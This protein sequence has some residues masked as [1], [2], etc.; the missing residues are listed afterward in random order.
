M[1][2]YC[3]PAHTTSQIFEPPLGRYSEM[4]RLTSSLCRELTYE[5]LNGPLFRGRT[6]QTPNQTQIGGFR[7]EEIR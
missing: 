4:D 5:D 1:Q 6:R 3:T 7:P 2:K